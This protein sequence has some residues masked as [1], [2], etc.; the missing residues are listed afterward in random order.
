MRRSDRMEDRTDISD[1][2]PNPPIKEPGKEPVPEREPV[3]PNPYPVT[4]PIP[5]PNP[6]PHP[7]PDPV[8][9]PRPDRYP[10][11]PEP[12]PQY[13]PDVTFD[14]RS[15]V[16]ILLQNTRLHV[17]SGRDQGRERTDLP[18]VISDQSVFFGSKA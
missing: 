4:D 18:A 7:E 12:I 2:R 15:L 6:A 1:S 9:S 14:M 10:T 8:P 3:T 11:P 13:P 17:C 5:D 16:H